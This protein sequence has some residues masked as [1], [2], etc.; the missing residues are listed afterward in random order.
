MLFVKCEKT[1]EAYLC[2]EVLK[3]VALHS[4]DAED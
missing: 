3:W 4:V 2:A 1:L